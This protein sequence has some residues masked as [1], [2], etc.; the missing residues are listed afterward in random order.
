MG[1]EEILKVITTGDLSTGGRMNPTQANRFIDY[2]VDNSE[3][4][5]SAQLVRMQADRFD[6]DTIAVGSRILRKC[7]EATAPADVA[8]VTHAKR[9][10]TVTEVILPFDISFSYL[11]DN[12]EGGDVQDHLM[13]LFAAQYANDLEDLGINGLGT[14]GDPFLS[15]EAGWIALAKDVNHTGVHVFDT[16]GSTSYL[17]VVFPGMVAAMPEKWKRAVGALEI[18]VSPA[19]EE[20]YRLEL[21]ARNSALGD[22]YLTKKESPAYLGWPV[23]PAPCL[24]NDVLLFTKPKN[25]AWGIHAR[26]LRV[27]K[28]I[29]ERKRVIEVT[30]TSRLDFE[31]VA[32]DQLVIG[33]N[34]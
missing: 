34:S 19:V 2:M 12:I 20:A 18:M 25:L 30:V 16:N 32:D 3:L 22:N 11:E 31:I 13:R 27:G 24:P 29:Q 6:L 26:H 5:R 8:G 17:E 9:Q 33:Y 23:R 4:L 10:L 15:I 7:V 21:T 14:G 1:I 28:Q